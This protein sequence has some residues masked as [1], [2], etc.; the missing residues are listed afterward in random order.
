[1]AAVHVA[2]VG[3]CKLAR[4]CPAFHDTCRQD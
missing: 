1:V 2:G 3:F 4:L